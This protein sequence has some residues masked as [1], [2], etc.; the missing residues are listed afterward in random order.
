MMIMTPAGPAG[1]QFTVGPDGRYRHA[2][3][4]VVGNEVE[5]DGVPFDLPDDPR[6]RADVL[7][8]LESY[9]SHTRGRRSSMRGGMW[10]RM[11]EM[12]IPLPPTYGGHH[13]LLKDEKMP[14]AFKEWLRGYKYGLDWGRDDAYN[15]DPAAARRAAERQ[16]EQRTSTLTTRLDIAVKKSEEILKHWR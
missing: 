11:S 14:V 16:H 9:L 15:V 8:A 10:E 12:V 3:V 4:R 5:M 1:E 2:D 13:L 6:E 7:Y